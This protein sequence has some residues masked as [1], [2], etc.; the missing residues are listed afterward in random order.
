MRL[1]LATYRRWLIWLPLLGAS[2]YLALQD[3][4]AE[5]VPDVVRPV[6][7][8][9]PSLIDP[10]GTG[11]SSSVALLKL[12]PR[13]QLMSVPSGAPDASRSSS[14]LFALRSWTPPPPPAPPP[15]KVAPTAPPLPFTFLGKKFQ[16]GQWEVFLGNGD[17]TYIVRE[18]LTFAAA[19]QVQS[20][21]PPNMTLVYMPLNQPQTLAIGSGL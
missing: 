8:S 21:Q 19:Y 11:S 13:D 16:D 15:P 3:P 1:S 6:E 12:V 9:E 17:F 4:P 14:D 2:A 7:R 20:I 5:D 10:S 18:G